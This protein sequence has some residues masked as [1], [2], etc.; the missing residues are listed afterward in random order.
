MK[1]KTAVIG[2]D[3]YEINKS[4]MTDRHESLPGITYIDI[5][6]YLINKKSAYT[7][8]ELKAVKSLDAYNQF[9]NGW[10]KDVM[11]MSVNNRVL[12]TGRVC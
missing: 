12:V 1:K 5:V 8:E 2:V 7:M 3:P 4:D 11:S 6:N 9:V 10:V